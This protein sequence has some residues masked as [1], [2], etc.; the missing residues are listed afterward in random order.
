MLISSVRSFQLI[1]T[2]KQKIFRTSSPLEKVNFF[3]S[4]S[5]YNFKDGLLNASLL[6]MSEKHHRTIILSRV[7]QLGKF[8]DVCL[9]NPFSVF[10]I[11]SIK[12]FPFFMQQSFIVTARQIMN[13]QQVT[14]WHIL[15]FTAMYTADRMFLHALCIR[16]IF[17]C[18]NISLSP[19]CE[20]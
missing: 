17:G 11:M 19:L 2:I 12:A 5:R 14:S 7:I 10:C 4:L 20:Q 3:I 6:T 16:E 8:V 18:I 1:S 13:C 15:K 9:L